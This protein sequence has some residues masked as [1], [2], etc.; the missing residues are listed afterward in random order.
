MYWE[1]LQ[2]LVQ[3]GRKAVSKFELPVALFERTVS[4]KIA[5]KIH[6]EW[7]NYCFKHIFGNLTKFPIQ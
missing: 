4:E 3:L 7:E 1:T 5:C 6:L 2:N